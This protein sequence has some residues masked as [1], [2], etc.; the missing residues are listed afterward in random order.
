MG[1]FGAGNVSAA[2]LF[3]HHTPLNQPPPIRRSLALK[4]TPMPRYVPL[5]RRGFTLVEL[6]V[7]IAIISTLKGLLLPAVQSA[8]EAARRNTCSNNLS[9]LGKALIAFDGRHQFVPGWKNRVTCRTG[10]IRTP[11]WSVMILPEIERRDIYNLMDSGANPSASQLEIYN[12]P[13][14]PAPDLSGNSI[15]YAGNCG[16]PSAPSRGEGLMFDTGTIRI[17]MDYVSGGDGCSNTLA[18]SEKNGAMVIGFP[19][20]DGIDSTGANIWNAG[21]W[22]TSGSGAVITSGSMQPLGFILPGT[23]SGRFI[24]SHDSRAE[25]S[26]PNSNHPGGVVSAF[27]DGHIRFLSDTIPGS[28]ISQ[29]MTSK[30]V[31]ARLEYKNLPILSDNY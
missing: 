30:S 24:N 11:P 29:L 22:T 16:D 21:V 2:V 6:L 5:A 19:R 10:A 3:P 9:Q 18:F 7:V 1:M 4:D 26:F 8:R 28:V 25:F 27:C 15:A 17:G 13:S 31:D 12:C 14:S 20:W 23:T